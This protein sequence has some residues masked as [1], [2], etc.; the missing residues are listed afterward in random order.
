MSRDQK[1]HVLAT[2]RLRQAE[3]SL[4]EARFLFEGEKSPRSII[5]RLSDYSGPSNKHRSA[6]F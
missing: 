5:N 1:K 2:Y 3:E 6:F 4:E